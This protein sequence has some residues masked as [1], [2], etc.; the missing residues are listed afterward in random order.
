MD[1]A[2]T[3]RDRLIRQITLI[4][5]DWGVRAGLVLW[6]K[7]THHNHPKHLKKQERGETRETRLA[8]EASE[9]R[10]AK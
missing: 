4:R 9:V 8:R 2:Y 1:L 7:R 6:G 5:E 3:C 10:E